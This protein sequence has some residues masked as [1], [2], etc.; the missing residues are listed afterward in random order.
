MRNNK[1]LENYVL[2]N[3]DFPTPKFYGLPKIHKQLA[4]KGIP[5]LRPIVAHSNS[6]LNHSAHFIDHTLQPIARIFPDYL[7]NSNTLIDKLSTLTLSKDVILVSMDVINLFPSIPQRE[8]LQIIHEEMFKHTDL[9]IVD[10]NFITTLLSINMNNNFFE[11]SGFT[12]Q[13]ILGTAME[14]LSHQQYQISTCPYSSENSCK[15]L[16]KNHFYYKDTSMTSS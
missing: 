13:Q 2:P 14:Q 16:Q 8:C 9:L 10:P 6:L 5:P 4:S 12:F 15:L 7:H 1:K 3:K 11:F